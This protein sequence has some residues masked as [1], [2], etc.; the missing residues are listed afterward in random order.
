MIP[1]TRFNTK[2]TGLIA[3]F[4][5]ESGRQRT[6]PTGTDPDVAADFLVRTTRPGILSHPAIVLM[7]NATFQGPQAAPGRIARAAG[8]KGVRRVAAA[9]DRC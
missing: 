6:Y 4:H 1:T 3:R 9:R 2:S 5:L 7:S 8:R